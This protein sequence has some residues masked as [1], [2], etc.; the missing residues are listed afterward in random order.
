MSSNRKEY[1]D[2][3]RAK[4]AA[5]FFLGFKENPATKLSI[6]AAMIAKGYLD[7]EAVDQILAQQVRRKSQKK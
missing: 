3:D 2:D 5:L 6:P 7:V 4:K 1:Q